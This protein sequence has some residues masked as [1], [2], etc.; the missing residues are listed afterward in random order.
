MSST[1]PGHLA[2]LAAALAANTGRAARSSAPEE[3]AEPVQRIERPKGEAGDGKNGFNLQEKMGL[4][5]DDEKYQ[6]ILVSIH[7]NV[8][9]ANVDITV[10]FRRQDPA[11]L[12]TVYKL[13]RDAHKPFL[14]RERFPLDWSSAEM[15]KQFLRNRRKYD[16]RQGRLAT[17]EER[18]RAAE[19]TAGGSSK[20]RK[21]AHIDDIEGSDS[22]I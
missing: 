1:C 19:Q 21:T 3:D 17:R 5:G 10:D 4:A 11:K 8:V 7:T 16:V 18:K 22:E 20:R 12:A 9:R 14:S 2:E 13:T 15:T 6:A